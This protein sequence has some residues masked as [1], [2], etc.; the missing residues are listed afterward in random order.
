M[1]SSLCGA[2][3]VVSGPGAAHTGPQGCFCIFSGSCHRGSAWPVMLFINGHTQ[4]LR[5]FAD[6][7]PPA[8]TLRSPGH[9]VSSP[10]TKPQ[11]GERHMRSRVQAAFEGKGIRPHVPLGRPAAD[12]ALSVP[13]TSP[14]PARQPYS[15]STALDEAER[16]ARVSATTH[17]PPPAW[18]LP[19]PTFLLQKQWNVQLCEFHCL[20]EICF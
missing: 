2:G 3:Q 9:P 16:Q 14:P 17:V 19:P 1:S 4:L 13:T 18:L 6:E 12:G 20:T 15:G 10:Q 7:K 11:A 8:G 5:C